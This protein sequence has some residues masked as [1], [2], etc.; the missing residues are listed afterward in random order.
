MISVFQ[1]HKESMR[2]E[3]PGN[4]TVII[5]GDHREG[6][7]SEIEIL[8][9]DIQLFIINVLTDKIIEKLEE[10]ECSLETIEKIAAILNI[11]I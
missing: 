9:A 4:K 7:D 6:E 11:R 1:T 3:S 5:E 2:E 10:E 8:L